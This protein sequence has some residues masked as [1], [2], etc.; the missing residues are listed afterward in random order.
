M[1]LEEAGGDGVGDGP[2][3]RLLDDQGLVLAEREG[4][5]LLGLQYGDDTHGEGLLRDVLLAEEAAGG[6]PAGDRVQ[7]HQPGPAGA[8]GPRLVEPDVP[9]PADAQDL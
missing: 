8:G 6:V 2:L 5:D 4:N 1:L 3:N 7:R 9:G